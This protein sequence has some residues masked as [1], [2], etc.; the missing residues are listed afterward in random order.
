[1][2]R[3]AFVL[4]GVE[5]GGTTALFNFLQ[6]HPQVQ[7]KKGWGRSGPSS[8][9]LFLGELWDRGPRGETTAAKAARYA[10]MFVGPQGLG[11]SGNGKNHGGSSD[12]FLTLA[13]DKT[14][15]YLALPGG[16]EKL[17]AVA[18][19]ARLI[20]S[21][22]EP[23]ARAISAYR[24][25]DHFR[26]PLARHVQ[27]ESALMDEFGV[28]PDNPTLK[29]FDAFNGAL[30]TRF[31]KHGRRY[32]RGAI[33]G[34]GLYVVML[35]HWMNVFRGV[36]EEPSSGSSK[37]GGRAASSGPHPLDSSRVKVIFLEEWRGGVDTTA[38]AVNDLFAWLG[39]PPRPASAFGDTRR[40][41][42]ATP[43]RAASG[44]PGVDAATKRRLQELY[45]PF[46][47][48]LEQLLG[49]KLPPSWYY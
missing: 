24:Y 31:T 10:N 21:L 26:G 49:R 1:M 4:P 34:F 20:I 36:E 12:P 27:D 47:R 11:C 38:A 46:N 14:P 6:S 2:P 18:P 25:F 30:L 37:S 8:E 32:H 17:K 23:V 9:T 33:V 5:K 42:N 19:E 35:R 7:T 43:K 3:P 40:G 16:A 44:K 15:S 28:R 39:L 13:G 48:E 45:A 29:E 22:R 41:I